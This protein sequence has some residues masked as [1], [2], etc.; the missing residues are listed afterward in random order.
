MPELMTTLGP[1][2]LRSFVFFIGLS[3]AASVGVVLVRLR[4]VAQAGHVVD[5][6]LGG[7]LGAVAGARL[8]HVALNWD[9]FAAH[10]GE[11]VRLSA[12]GLDW[13]GALFG[14]LLGLALV[15][16][17]RRLPL[18]VL[19][20]A[21]TPVLPLIALGVWYGC[22]AAACGYGREV[23]TLANYPAY[24]VAELPD[25]YGIVAPRYSTQVFGLGLSLG[26]LVVAVALLASGRLAGRRFWGVLAL[27]GAGLFA[28]GFYRGDASAFV[29][30][31]RFDQWLDL[32]VSIVGVVGFVLAG[33]WQ[34]TPQR[35]SAI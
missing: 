9:T 16:R 34:A 7:L 22:W 3:L 5:A 35:R 15:A 33:R 27:L 23:D 6:L 32:L 20:D 17:W 31:L 30:G 18:S 2:T 29:G 11:I 1:L 24:A 25:V 14:G 8:G 21:L 12:G 26:L 28:I 4:P 19:L 10:T 13:H